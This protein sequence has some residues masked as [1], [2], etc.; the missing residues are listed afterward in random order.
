MVEWQLKIENIKLVIYNYLNKVIEKNVTKNCAVC[1]HSHYTGMFCVTCSAVE[2]VKLIFCGNQHHVT[3][4]VD[5][6]KSYI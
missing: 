4:A 5:R 2:Q 1:L 6:A 3:E